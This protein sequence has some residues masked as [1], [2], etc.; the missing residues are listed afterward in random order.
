M[1]VILKLT[2]LVLAIV[3]TASQTSFAAFEKPVGT[4]PSPTVSSIYG[5][6]F[7][8]NTLT[9]DD[10]LH[11]KNRQIELKIGQKLT[12]KHKIVLT[13]VKMKL[14]KELKKGGN[15]SATLSGANNPSG[16]QLNVLG[17]ILG[18]LLSLLGVLLAFVFI[19]RNAGISSLIGLAVLI[20]L[21]GGYYGLRSK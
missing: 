4:T 5:V 9:A 14:K 11:L 15:G 1:K 12:W 3:L 19:G 20:V 2:T 13:L 16:F 18:L 6:P 8:Q 10:I 21:V 17:F 7:G